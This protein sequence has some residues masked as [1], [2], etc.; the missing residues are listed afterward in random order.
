[1]SNQESLHAKESLHGKTVAIISTHGFEQSELF[2]PKQE[3]EARGATTHVVSINGDSSI[4]GWDEKDWGDSVAVD[5][6]IENVMPEDYD[7]IVL[8]GGQINPDIL[9]NNEDVVDFIQFASQQDKIKAIGAICH[10]PWLL[11]EAGLV[12]DKDVTSYSSIRTDVE[13]AGGKWQD[14]TV[15]TD[16]KLVTSR[17]PDDIPNFV[18]AI[19]DKLAA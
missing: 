7:A 11:V 18:E 3:L 9:R 6:Q 8:P 4:K 12:K 15:V 13:N 2:K 1:M 5:K 10:G 19:A 14:K 17:N 16:G